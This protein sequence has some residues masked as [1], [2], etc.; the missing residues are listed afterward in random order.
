LIDHFGSGGAQRQIVNLGI[1][2]ARRGQD[3]EFAIYY[4]SFDYHRSEVD[5]A[6]IPVYEIPKESRYS[7]SVPLRLRRLLTDRNYDAVLS[8]LDVPGVYAILSVLGRKTAVV[9][10]ER[11]MSQRAGPSI[12]Q[13]LR[14]NL[15]RRADHIVTNS[16]THREWILRNFPW[17]AGRI[18]TIYNGIDLK[19]FAPPKQPFVKR[20]KPR[21]VAVGTL[22]PSKNALGLLRA[23]EN[24]HISDR[25]Q[26]INWV[27]KADET[28]RGSLYFNEI[29]SYLETSATRV[30][31]SWLGE[32]KDVAPIVRAHDALIH[33][34][35][36]E[37]LPNAACEAMAC[38]RPVLIS[39][40]GDHPRIVQEG[41]TGFLF[42]PLDVSSI[43]MAV[44]RFLK[45]DATAYNQ[46]CCQ[47]RAIAEESFSLEKCAAAYERVL[48]QSVSM[49]RATV[50]TE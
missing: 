39:D 43:Q 10:S 46:M 26:S 45:L 35:L 40:V 42:D 24:N 34:S 37:G 20:Q 31:W 1:E 22:T 15:Y 23:F 14:I 17:T 13:R 3:V 4:P 8:Y 47:A 12:W 30:S 16:H 33:P 32:W 6:G 21:L 18:S 2:L 38:A 25:V 50:S 11:S 41:E 9:V 19:R 5:D 48:R 44:G 49:R 27:G 7:L 29:Q 28:P 36:F